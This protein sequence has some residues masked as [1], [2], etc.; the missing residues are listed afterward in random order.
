MKEALAVFES[1]NPRGYTKRKVPQS[2]N[3]E[4][5]VLFKTKYNITLLEGN[6]IKFE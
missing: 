2:S 5:K 1:V 6:Y 3:S 4:K